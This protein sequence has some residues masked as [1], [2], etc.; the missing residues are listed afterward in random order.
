MSATVLEELANSGEA[1]THSLASC[2]HISD[3]GLPDKSCCPSA[4]LSTRATAHTNRTQKQSGRRFAG[5]WLI[6]D[7]S[8]ADRIIL[9]GRGS[10]R[11]SGPVAGCAHCRKTRQSPWQQLM[12]PVGEQ[13]C[14]TWR[15][16]ELPAVRC[17][18]PEVAALSVANPST[19]CVDDCGS[20][21][22][23][24]GEPQSQ[25]GS[26]PLGSRLPSL[27]IPQHCASCVCTL[28]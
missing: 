6:K 20:D 26:W 23:C 11:E 28:S 17:K 4:Q 7:C 19:H 15:S 8:Q 12:G 14:S 27:S 10:P 25:A 2:A 21:M 24:G 1:H 22:S 9:P 5:R 13:A 16:I 18:A 3:A